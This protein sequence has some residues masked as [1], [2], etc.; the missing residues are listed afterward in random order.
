MK[1]YII[2]IFIL[3]FLFSLAGCDTHGEKGQD[4]LSDM[5]ESTEENRL[6]DVLPEPLVT[7]TANGVSIE[8]YL[9]A[10][11]G[12]EW[13]DN[14]FLFWD[15]D[16]IESQLPELMTDGLIP[17]LQYV[18]D[19]QIT[20]GTKMNGPRFVL[21]YDDQGHLLCELGSLQEISG[22]DVDS[23]EY[24]VDF[25]ITKEGNYIEEVNESEYTVY[26]CVFRLVI[27]E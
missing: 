11:A 10:V 15:S 9:H 25:A 21:L 13:L 16:S 12:A 1:R 5:T 3:I 2:L 4:T 26:Q 19:I 14:G 6:P 7:V 24:Y 8:P 27:E 23:G 22:S 17:Q 18:K 20:I